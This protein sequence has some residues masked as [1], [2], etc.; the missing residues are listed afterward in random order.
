MESFHY[1]NGTKVWFGKACV[2]QNLPALLGQY[3]EAVMLAYGGGS[4]K[5]NGV[6]DEVVSI[7]DSTNISAG[8]CKKL[9]HDEIYEIL[10]ECN[11]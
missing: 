3:G 7:A 11:K 4:I 6:Y 10:K 1:E 5:R 2:P 9:T 8:C